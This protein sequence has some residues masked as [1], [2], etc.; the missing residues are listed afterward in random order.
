[1]KNVQ[2]RKNERGTTVAEF[3]LVALTFFGLIFGIIEFGRMLYTHNAL[4]DATRRGARYAV[5]HNADAVKVKNQVVYGSNLTV[6]DE[7]NVTSAPLIT[8]LTPEM[9]QVTYEG[10][11]LDGDP[12]TDPT[13]FGSNLGTA[14]VKI[15]NFSFDLMI[16]LIGR[17]VPMGDYSTTLSAESAGELPKDITD[18]EPTPVP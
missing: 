1:M 15:T 16:P 14:T 7:G 2:L 4:A 5:L 8:G 10:E 3:A 13:N 17:P 6:D 18:P 11:D 12:D 9:V